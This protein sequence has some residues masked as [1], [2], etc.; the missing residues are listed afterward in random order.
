MSVDKEGFYAPVFNKDLCTSCILCQKVCPILNFKFNTQPNE[1]F[2]VMAKGEKIRLSCSSNG[3][4]YIL[5]KYVI[6]QG[7]YVCGLSQI[8]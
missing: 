5:S 3:V 2:A 8:I 1:T 4:A 6:E 7:G